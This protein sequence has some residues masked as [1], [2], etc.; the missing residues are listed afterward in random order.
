MMKRIVYLASFAALVGLTACGSESESA[1]TEDTS[2]AATR[3]GTTVL[4]QVPASSETTK[5]LGISSWT[6]LQGTR[7]ADDGSTEQA[8]GWAGV[9]ASGKALGIVTYQFFTD[10][11]GIQFDDTKSH[12]YMTLDNKNAVIETTMPPHAAK[13]S[14]RLSQDIGATKDSMIATRA[15]AGGLTAYDGCTSGREIGKSATQG[16]VIGGTIGLAVGT[17]VAGAGELISAPAGCL[18][19]GVEGPIKNCLIKGTVSVFKGA[20]HWFAD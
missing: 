17:P 3:P 19:G 14:E 16:C 13:W 8:I 7:T 11:T 1:S 20:Y 5:E 15:V 18:I 12:G 10:G 2:E 6:E 9:D 4:D